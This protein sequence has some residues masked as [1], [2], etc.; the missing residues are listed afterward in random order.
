MRLPL[1]AMFALLLLAGCPPKKPVPV[2]NPTETPGGGGT[3][4]SAPPVDSS[5]PL[6]ERVDAAADLIERGSP[7]ELEQAIA[8]L[9]PAAA[10]DPTGNA[11]FNLGLAYQKKGDFARASNQY[12]QVI[13]AH[14]DHGRA[15]AALGAVQELQGKPNDAFVSYETGIKSAPDSIELRAALIDSLRRQGKLDEA[16]KAA[17]EALKVNAKYLPVYNN[18]GLVYLD[19]GNLVLAKFVFQK[20]VQEIEGAEKSAD[21]LTNLGWTY[22]LEDNKPEATTQLK[23]ALAVEPD[24]VPALV[25]LAR[26]YMDDHNYTDTV[27]L[28]E[29]AVKLDPNNGDL[30]LTLGVAY[31]GMN[32]LDDA[33]AAYDKAL[34]LNPSDPAPHFNQGVLLGDYRKDYTGAV[35]AFNRY[36]SAG[37]PERALA[38]T[39]IKDI[40]KEK[41]NAE[42]RAKAEAERKA[43]EEERKRKEELL[44]QPEGQPGGETPGG[45]PGEAPGGEAPPP[46]PE[47]APQPAPETP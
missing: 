34:A 14:P 23:A 24:L 39:Y 43:K 26:V 33:K 29:Q 11:R 44:K 46:E 38:E 32:R 40:E 47:P 36:I 1:R 45:T 2:E 9:E 21:L 4:P 17:Q 28:L 18:F 3:G 35:E 5:A 31:R 20:A 10:E 7:S 41:S 42:K 37:G 13:S 30:Y 15:W 12:T 27:P 19:K 25:Y 8:I 22:Y 6:D 16:L